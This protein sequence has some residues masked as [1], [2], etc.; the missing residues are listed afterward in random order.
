MYR[1]TICLVLHVGETTKKKNKNSQESTMALKKKKKQ[2]VGAMHSAREA[3]FAQ[4]G[5]NVTDNIWY[6]DVQMLT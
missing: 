3:V 4:S 1:Q 2:V 5:L 6:I